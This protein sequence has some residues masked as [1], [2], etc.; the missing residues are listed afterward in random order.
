MRMTILG[1]GHLGWAVAATA[2]E[3]GLAA[4]V[5]GRPPGARHDP[6]AFSGSDIVI[7][8]TR[9]DAVA[10]NVEAAIDAG[11]R[12]F[13]MA[14]TGWDADGPLVDGR[15]RAAG[16]TAVVAPN[17][18]HGVALF[19]RLVEVAAA[20]Y[21]G[22]DGFEPYLLEWHRAGKRDRPSGTARDLARRL[23]AAD[24]RRSDP[25]GLEVASLRAGSSPGVHVVGFD[26]PGETVELRH[27]ARDRSGFA[28]GILASADW[29]MG[30]QHAPGIHPFDL[31]VDDLLV[32]PAAAA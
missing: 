31:V 29:L 32:R 4:R 16:A 20:W 18:S 25:D 26:A 23:A 5:V 27:A 15:V 13:V 14:T 8:A 21:G 24:P 28:A 1:D 9:G 11:V 2:T 7:D 30:T 17:F 19:G 6:A 3:R 22:V 10:G 12:R